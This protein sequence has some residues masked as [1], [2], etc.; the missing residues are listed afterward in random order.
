MI[1]IDLIEGF[2]ESLVQ[3]A[4]PGEDIA[5]WITRLPYNQ[6]FAAK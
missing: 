3:N 6:K 4:V 5:M 1:A 2:S